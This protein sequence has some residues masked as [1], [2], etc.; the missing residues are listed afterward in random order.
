MLQDVTHSREVHI[1]HHQEYAC[2]LRI[3][4]PHLGAVDDVI[5]LVF[6]SSR[7]QRKGVTP[8]L[9]FREAEASDLW[10]RKQVQKEV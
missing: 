9:G 2:M 8:R 6:F 7:L 5:V 4:D 10:D 3:T 1:G